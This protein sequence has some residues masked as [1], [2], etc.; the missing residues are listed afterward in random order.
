M[1]GEVTCHCRVVEFRCFSFRLSSR[2]P[3]RCDYVHLDFFAQGDE[4][5]LWGFGRF[6]LVF[7][8]HPPSL[9]DVSHC[10]VVSLLDIRFL[11]GFS[12]SSVDDFSEHLRTS[13]FHFGD[14][15]TDRR[16]GGRLCFVGGFRVPLGYISSSDSEGELDVVSF[17]LYS[18]VHLE[19]SLV[20][21]SIF[22]YGVGV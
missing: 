19:G 7:H 18:V 5:L 17:S 2:D 4:A 10:R 14:I 11:L 20:P 6:S 8:P 21:F 15:W 3:Y 9:E 22:V 16:T 13:I 1:G 12:D